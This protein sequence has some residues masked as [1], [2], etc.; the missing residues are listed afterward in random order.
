MMMMMGATEEKA[1]QVTFFCLL[2]T[3]GAFL[4]AGLVNQNRH[5]IGVLRFCRKRVSSVQITTER[6]CILYQF[7]IGSIDGTE[8]E[9]GAS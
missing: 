2:W 3:H 9:I 4:V 8:D 6:C 7:I 5:M 1:D